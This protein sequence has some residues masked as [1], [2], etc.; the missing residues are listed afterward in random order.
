VRHLLGIE[1]LSKEEL[2]LLIENSKEMAQISDRE[3]KKVPTLR[4]KTIINLF[5]EPSTRTR[6]SFEIAGKRLSADVVNFSPSGSSLSKGETLLDTALNLQSMNP[7]ILVVRHSASGAPH[8]LA[9]QLPSARIVNA[10]DGTHEHPTQALLDCATLK[11]AMEERGRSLEGLKIAIV[12]DIIHSRVARSNIFAH[13]SLGNQINLVGPRTLVPRNIVKSFCTES[14]FKDSIGSNSKISVF[15]NLEEGLAGV[16]AVICLRMQ[17]ER[18]S[19]FYVASMDDYSLKYCVSEK[20]LAKVAPDALILHPGPINRGIEVST[21]V[22]DGPRSLVQRQV[23][24]GVAVRMAVL[25]SLLAGDRSN[26][27]ES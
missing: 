26:S 2:L 19:G 4:G 11:E 25:H 18:Q 15:D 14:F 5:F 12:G 21:E 9:K 7:D 20:I 1:N 6:S 8:F 23:R 10:G 3:I 24:Y 17:T 27:E 22:I 13:L 16:D